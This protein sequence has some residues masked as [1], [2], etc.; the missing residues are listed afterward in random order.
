MPDG[1][2][3]PIAA[4]DD[5]GSDLAWLALIFHCGDDAIVLLICRYECG[6][7][8]NLTAFSLQRFD[9][10]FFSHILRNHGHERI[11]TLLGCK[12]HVGKRTPVCHYCDRRDAVRHLEKWSDEPGHVKDLNRPR[13]DCERFGM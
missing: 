6:L 3:P 1:A 2:V 9:E 7:V 4:N 11:G 10:Q 8:F 12:P 5:G 13:K